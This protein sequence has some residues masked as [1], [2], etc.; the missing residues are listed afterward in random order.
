LPLS[1]IITYYN[2]LFWKKRFIRHE[3]FSLFTVFFQGQMTLIFITWCMMHNDGQQEWCYRIMLYFNRN[4]ISI[5]YYTVTK[6]NPCLFQNVC[7]CLRVSASDVCMCL[8]ASDRTCWWVCVCAWSCACMC[9]CMFWFS[10]GFYVAPI[11]YIVYSICHMAIFKLNLLRKTLGAD[12][13]IISGTEGPY[14]CGKWTFFFP[15]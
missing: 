5:L 9:T 4:R 14:Y 1:L 11:Q 6:F 8:R 3:G 7:V 13:C 10:V 2:Q 12:L 15:Y